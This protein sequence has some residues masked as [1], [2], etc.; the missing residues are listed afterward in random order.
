MGER[1]DEI[2][3]HISAT[4]SELGD[5]IDELQQKVKTTFDWRAQFQQRPWIL[6][7]A[8]FGGGLL[9]SLLIPGRRS[10]SRH[11]DQRWRPE[12]YGRSRSEHR[13]LEYG[14]GEGRSAFAE[15]TASVWDNIR[16]ALLTAGVSR[17]TS[18][19]EELLPGFH[20]QFR[21]RQSQSPQGRREY[22]LERRQNPRRT[23]GADEASESRPAWRRNASGETDFGPD[24]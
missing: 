9:V 1:T 24:A 19:V 8:A 16:S 21:Q 12:R 6:A 18:F 7:G 14:G 20:E 23:N 11:R 10:S 13:R 22:Q 15:K 3:R 5:N 2:E 17:L 4:R